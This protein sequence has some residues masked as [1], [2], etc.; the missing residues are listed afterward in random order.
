MA[1]LQR[2]WDFTSRV[3]ALSPLWQQKANMDLKRTKLYLCE[4][5]PLRFTANVNISKFG[6]VFP[7]IC[8]PFYGPK[9]SHIG[10]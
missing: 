6:L 3:L 2:L 5:C 8:D 1:K 9:I 10:F 4:S 7:N